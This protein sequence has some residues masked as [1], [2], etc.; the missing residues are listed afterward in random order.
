MAGSGLAA[1]E[2]KME[3]ADTLPFVTAREQPIGMLSSPRKRSAECNN[4]KGVGPVLILVKR[5]RRQFFGS[6]R[7]L[8]PR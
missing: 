7:D 3:K 4:S 8:A 2:A 5:A 6:V 1:F